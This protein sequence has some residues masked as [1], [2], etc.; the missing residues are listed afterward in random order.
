MSLRGAPSLTGSKPKSSTSSED[1]SKMSALLDA[2]I[3]TNNDNKN[4]SFAQ[5]LGLE[6]SN[7]A[8]TADIS[9]STAS[10]NKSTGESSSLLL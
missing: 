6:D 8:M 7:D 9:S 3:K 1:L 10:P 4:K 2:P 5:D